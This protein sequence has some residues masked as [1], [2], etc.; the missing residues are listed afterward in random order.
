MLLGKEISWPLG[1]VYTVNLAYILLDRFLSSMPV[2]ILHYWHSQIF[3]ISYIIFVVV[4]AAINGVPSN[5]SKQTA[6]VNNTMT[7]DPVTG[8]P[9]NGDLNNG[10]PVNARPVNDDPILLMVQ[11]ILKFKANVGVSIGRICVLLFLII[12][13][14]QVF[15][16]ILY[17][18]REA[19][20]DSYY[21]RKRENS[22][23]S[24]EQLHI[25][26]SNP[27]IG[28]CSLP[29]LCAI[30]SF[31]KQA[32]NSPSYPYTN[33]SASLRTAVLSNEGMSS[34]VSGLDKVVL[35]VPSYCGRE[36]RKIFGEDLTQTLPALFPPE[37]KHLHLESDD[38]QK[39]MTKIV[40]EG[41]EKKSPAGHL[42]V[43]VKDSRHSSVSS[44]ETTDQA[45]LGVNNRLMRSNRMN[46]IQAADRSRHYSFT[47]DPG[48]EASSLILEQND[49][50]DDFSG[51]E[52]ISCKS[53]SFPDEASLVLNDVNIAPH[54]ELSAWGVTGISSKSVVPAS[55]DTLIST[56]DTSDESL[57]LKQRRKLS[58]NKSKK[59]M[60][61]RLFGK[62][63]GS[64]TPY[65]NVGGN[66]LGI[67]IITQS[68]STSG[69]EDKSK[70]YLQM[71]SNEESETKNEKLESAK[72]PARE[73]AE[74]N[75]PTSEQA[76]E[77]Q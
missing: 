47:M 9:V 24:K 68:P 48:S 32:P 18:V 22:D 6:G 51:Y 74:T 7:D 56:P 11:T 60:E 49:F 40:M 75:K 66:S 36:D 55:D 76:G 62:R 71:E 43:P 65:D 57:S 13:I 4:H 42:L 14:L 23:T 64:I 8:D 50:V 44:C 15:Y 45:M 31:N 28:E 77:A 69:A 53:S 5:V 19:K 41:Q 29:V 73:T 34:Q 33:K 35:Q 63:K 16:Y 25:P 12:P 17:V 3:C 20:F 38:K 61:A 67:S 10:D 46:L 52:D 21:W 72:K 1:T 27:R 2:N 30:N 37:M 26:D 59:A 70:Q 54:Y 58:I 39:Q